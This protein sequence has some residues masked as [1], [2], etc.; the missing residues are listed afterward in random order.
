VKTICASLPMSSG[1]RAGPMSAHVAAHFHA[2]KTNH[3]HSPP[4]QK[5]S[6]EKAGQQKVEIR[7]TPGSTRSTIR[8]Q[9]RSANGGRVRLLETAL[10][11]RKPHVRACFL[12]VAKLRRQSLIVPMCIF[13]PV[14]F[15]LNFE[16]HVRLPNQPCKVMRRFLEFENVRALKRWS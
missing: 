9:W 12:S 7:L 4:R 1:R 11:H 10:V 6:V 2:T 16:R 14:R 8:C 13:H 15:D 5:R 3:T